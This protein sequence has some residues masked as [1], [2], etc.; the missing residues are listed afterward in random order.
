MN[1]KLAPWKILILALLVTCLLTLVFFFLQLPEAL[2]IGDYYYFEN[3][4]P[5]REKFSLGV[6][7]VRHG[8]RLRFVTPSYTELMNSQHLIE[9]IE[10]EGQKAKLLLFNPT[11]TLALKNTDVAL[12]RLSAITIGMGQHSHLRFDYLLLPSDDEQVWLEIVEQVQTL[13]TAIL[14]D[15]TSR[16]LVEQMSERFSR[17]KPLLLEQESVIST[18]HVENELQKLSNAGIVR[19]LVVQGQKLELYSQHPL[20][21]G[22][23]FTVDGLYRTAF[24]PEQLDG[25]LFD[26]V[27]ASLVVALKTL[28]K[29]AVT[30]ELPLER[31]LRQ[32][33]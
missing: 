33:R 22:L 6:L 27:G 9:T 13:P 14:F 1:L 8:Y 29:N 26:D 32:S 23:R 4:F 3:M 12:E 2:F 7:F 16:S 10:T 5:A 30:L 11:L 18:P 19:L 15:Q 25:W 24:A 28:R 21:K 31:A 17:Q 20:A